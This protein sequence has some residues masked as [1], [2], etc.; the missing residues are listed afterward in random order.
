M[1]CMFGAILHVPLLVAGVQGR[2]LET[3]G[4]MLTC[5]MMPWMVCSA[6]TRRL[7]ARFAV[8]TLAVA[9]MVFAGSAYLL[10]A[11]RGLSGLGP[12]VSAMVLLGTGL[13]LTVA[14]LLIVVQNAVPKDRLGAA[15]SLTQFTRSMGAG[16][17]LA[18]MGT[19]FLAPFGGR[20][21]QGI[22]RFRTRLDPAELA[23]LLAPLSSGITQVFRAGA[24]AAALGLVLAL[25][26]PSGTAAEHRRPG[27][28]P[29]GAPRS[30]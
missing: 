25:L 10:L 7:L 30:E 28:S 4:L 27:E 20:E 5:M 29:E 2:S 11:A 23:A 21:P 19:L 16:L 15:T 24:V 26:M 1:I 13:G 3:G 18:V 22:L 14:P 9:G 17:G 8:R 6:M 12:L